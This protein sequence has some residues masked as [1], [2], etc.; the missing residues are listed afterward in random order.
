MYSEAA[1][2]PKAAELIVNMGAIPGRVALDSL[3]I[4]A[5]GFGM[6]CLALL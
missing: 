1:K 3:V 2:S 5:Y 6:P 4:A